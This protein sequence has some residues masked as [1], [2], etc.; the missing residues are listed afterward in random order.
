M[1][2][3]DDVPFDVYDDPDSDASTWETLFKEGSEGH[4][5]VDAAT[6]NYYLGRIKQNKEKLRQ[7]ESQAKEMKD[8]FKVRVDGWL[9]SRQSAL[10]YDNQHCLEI[11]EM[12]FE[13][14]KPARGKTISLPEG[15]IGLY[16]TPEK[17]DFDTHKEDVLRYLQDHPELQK[18]IRN[19][20]EINRSELKKACSFRDG[21]IYV[22][23]L[24][25]PNVTY[26]P[27]TDQ[28]SIR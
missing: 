19:K 8:D 5:P 24:E 23:D 21:K 4:R 18:Y 27:K 12:Y 22:G 14:N 9:Q 3:E 1:F 10:E 26:S 11:L 6:A 7:Y 17:Y 13:D 28:F 20:P 16:A 15:N 2:L 25:L